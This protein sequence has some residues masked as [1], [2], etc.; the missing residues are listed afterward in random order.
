MSKAKKLFE[1]Y[2]WVGEISNKTIIEL[3]KTADM[4][5]ELH[6]DFFNKFD[7]SSTKFNL[8]VIL[9]SGSKEG[10]ML[11]EIGEQMLV[12]RANI[13]GLVDRLEKQGFV[14][15]KRH[16]LDR[17]KIMATIT[18]EGEQFTEETIKAYRKWSKDVMLILDDDEKSNLIGLLKKM[19]RG[20]LREEFI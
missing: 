7:I 5:E 13:T 9:Y 6:N 3:K 20:F 8:L 12:T 4:L 14:K 1:S 18:K 19:Q 11:S 10:M 16:H 17:R 15:R 2:E